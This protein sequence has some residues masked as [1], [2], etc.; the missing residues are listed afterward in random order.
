MGFVGELVKHVVFGEGKIIEHNN[1]FIKISFNNDDVKDFIYPD[2][3][4]VYLELENKDLLKQVEEDKNTKIKIEEEKKLKEELKKQREI[5]EKKIEEKDNVKKTKKVKT[6]SNVAFKCNYCDGGSN[7]DSIGYK[8]VCSDEI[9]NYNVN[10]IKHIWCRDPDCDCYQYLHN[11]IS[12]EYLESKC[13]KANVCYE[14]QMLVDWRAFAGVNHSGANKGKP[15]KLRNVC[16]NSLALLTTR[17]PNDKEKNRFIFA[18]FLILENY[19]GDYKEEGYI[20]ANERYRIELS[21]EEA[22]KLKFW[23]YYFNQKKPEKI[24]FGSG[25]YRYI[26][27]IQAAQILKKI[28]EIKKNTADEEL[29]TKF[30]EHYCNIKNLDIKEIPN[31]NG[32]LQRVACAV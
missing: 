13:K 10:N 7:N 15:R 23:D 27:D 30:F 25:L 3:I 4:G 8:S 5:E 32:P 18:A 31:P 17:L 16:S 26:S 11:D 19:E 9:I 6:D 20:A 14:S 21:L 28:C 2:A 12:R 29:A 24:V 22:K 1:D